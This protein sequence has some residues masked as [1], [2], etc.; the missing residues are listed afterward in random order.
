MSF[1]SSVI[2]KVGTKVNAVLGAGILAALVDSSVIFK[3][4]DQWKIIS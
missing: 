2:R 4:W 3:R 1:G